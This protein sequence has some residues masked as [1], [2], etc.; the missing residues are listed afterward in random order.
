M[1]LGDVNG[2]RL[3]F[4]YRFL[5]TLVKEILA[6]GTNLFPFWKAIVSELVNIATAFIWEISTYMQ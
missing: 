5:N 1:S 2:I 3:V 6:F 4:T